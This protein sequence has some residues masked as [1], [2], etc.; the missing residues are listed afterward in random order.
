MVSGELSAGATMLA[1]ER[2]YDV[3]EIASLWNFSRDK[4]RDIFANEPG[5]LVI[6]NKAAH[7]RRY[8]TMRIPESVLMRVHRRLSN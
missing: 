4:V 5:V 6:A 7:K 8:R 2:H 1:V 3:A